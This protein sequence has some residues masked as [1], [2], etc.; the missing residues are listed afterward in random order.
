MSGA[1]SSSAVLSKDVSPP[2]PLLS[3]ASSGKVAHALNTQKQPPPETPAARWIRRIVVL[4]F[5]AVFLLLGLPVWYK[6]TSIYR[7]DL[8]LGSMIDWS[9][10]KVCTIET[11]HRICQWYLIT[12]AELQVGVSS[13]DRA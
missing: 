1:A 7:A 3:A 13:K 6:T 8:P 11:C 12:Y 2:R 4:S 9:E 10:G 5:L